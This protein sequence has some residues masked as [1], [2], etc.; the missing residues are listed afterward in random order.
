MATLS[1]TTRHSGDHHDWDSSAYVSQWAEGQDKKEPLRQAAFRV[2]AESISH[3][4]TKALR[5]LDVGAGYGALTQFLLEYFPNA[6]AV[7]QD[8]SQEM[9]KLGHERM[10]TYKGRFS[11]VQSDFG[12]SGW[13]KALGEPFEAVVSAIAIH[14]V[15]DPKVIQ[16]IYGEI[17]PLLKKGGCFLNFDRL[18]PSIEE[19]VN[20]LKQL[21]Y[22]DANCSWQDEKH[23]LLCGLRGE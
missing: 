9:I 8:G 14:N 3:D 7:C 4:K 10:A 20:W 16:S 11:Y 6:T 21:G 15:R 12:K 5:I 13:S 23:G 17:L 19:Q 2:I 18:R 22:V 1:H